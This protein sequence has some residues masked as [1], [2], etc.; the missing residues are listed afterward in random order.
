MKRL[1]VLALMLIMGFAYS[2]PPVRSFVYTAGNII[3]PTEVTKNEDNIFQYLT[4]GVDTLANNA[5]TTGKI[6]DS[7]V[8]SAKILDAS[9]VGADIASGTIVLSQLSPIPM[10]YTDARVKIGTFTRDFTV[11]SADVPYVGV[12]FQPTS[13]IFFTAI[14]GTTG[15]S[16]GFDMQSAHGVILDDAAEAAT[17]WYHSATFSIYIIQG[18]GIGETGV[19]LSLDADGFTIR[20]ARIGAAGGTANIYYMAL[21]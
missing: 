15:M 10:A 5:V 21:R 7:A 3:Q 13:V 8:N 14:T 2:A 4:A 9:I 11:A 16:A 18:V 20:W 19:V 17:T 1:L 12:G 6:L